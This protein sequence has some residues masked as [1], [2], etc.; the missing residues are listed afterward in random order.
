MNLPN[1]SPKKPVVK[2][3]SADDKNCLFENKLNK[4]FKVDLPNTVW[5][6]DITYL[7]AGGR[8][9][10][11]AVVID[12]SSR[13]IIGFKLS[14]TINTQ[15]AL[16]AFNIAFE[17]RGRPDGVMFH[18]DRGAQYTSKE[19]MKHLFSLGVVQ[20]F[21]A[22]GHPYDNAVCECFFKYLKKEETNRKTYSTYTELGLSIFEYINS[23]YNNMRPH[24]ANG[25]LS[26]NAYEKKYL[27]TVS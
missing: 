2:V 12:L 20:S 11:L 5:C 24:S 7:K 17:S 22:K 6:G 8:P 18:S 3:K 16:D 10:Y 27:D 21:S 15:L 25:N 23:F 14:S 4:Q 13:K 26:P 1:K 9:Y 19:Y